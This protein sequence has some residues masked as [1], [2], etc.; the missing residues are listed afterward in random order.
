MSRLVGTEKKGEGG[1]E[2]ERVY[3]C[4]GVAVKGAVIGSLTRVVNKNR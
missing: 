4:V 1:R 3:V 2:R